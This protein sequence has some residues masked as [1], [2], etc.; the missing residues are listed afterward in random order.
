[1]LGLLITFG[2]VYAQTDRTGRITGRI[3]SS[4]TQSPLSGVTVRVIGTDK[5][6]I[7]KK[8]GSFDVKDVPL[9]LQKVQFNLIGYETY[10]QTDV[11]VGSGKPAFIEVKL[12]EK[13]IQLEGAEVRASYFIKKSETVTSTQNL[14]FED[15]RR[16]PGVQEDVIRA[17]QLLPGVNIS[18]AGRN[19]LVVRGGA[20]FENLFMVDGLEV[21]NINHFGSQGSTGGPLSIIN[22]DFIRNV[23][24]SAGGFGAKYGDRTSSVTN[25]QLR[26]GNE[27][28]FGGKVVLSAIGFGANLE[29][30]IG[31]KGSWFFSARRSYLD[32]LFQLA[33]FAFVP[34]YWDFQGKVNYRLDQNNTLTFMTISAINN[35]SLNNEDLD[36]RFKNSQVAIPDQY[37]NFSGLTWKHL[38]GNGFLTV[39]AGSSY[40]RFTT[41]QNDSNLVEIFRNDSKEGEFILRTDVDYQLGPKTELTFGNQ[42]KYGGM[43]EYDI[44]IPGFSRRDQNGIPQ[45]LSVD[46]NFA[47]LKNATYASLST[48]FGN[49][50]VTAGARLD[51]YNFTDGEVF[52]SPRLAYTYTLN[53]NSTFIGSIGRYYQAPSYIWLVGSP[54]NNLKPIQADQI[55]LGYAHTPLEDVKVQLEVFYKEYKNYPARIFRPQAVLAPSGFDDISSDIPF[56]LEPLISEGTGVSRGAELFIQK[57][58]SEIPIYGLLSLTY[59]QTNFVSLDGVERPS[60]FDSRFI[61]NFAIGWRIDELWEISTKFRTASGVP[62][63]PFTNDGRLDFTR[64]NEGERLPDFHSADLRIDKRW[65][66]AGSTLITYID[67]QNI[68]GQKNV[69]GIRWNPRLGEA[70]FNRSIGVLPSIGVSWEF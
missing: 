70:E 27:T 34:Q 29:G 54:Q 4:M 43:L 47:A 17:V 63:T 18:S 26:N 62:T 65:N 12:V 61:F 64:Y 45:A 57:K 56:G 22:L 2:S 42:L 41:F 16:A 13:V 25:I 31:D 68:Y 14:S 11:S 40:T 3:T 30:P 33:G 9:G 60:A 52:F 69:S 1:M 37:Q 10:V 46:T 21:N 66:L 20:P 39:T 36:N 44:L 7:S 59:A 49:H 51:Y 8:D 67:I 50:R 35:V 55:V 48:G 53:E 6:A 28:Q 15:I 5:G 58:F 32:L 24:F 38:F 19:D 23:D